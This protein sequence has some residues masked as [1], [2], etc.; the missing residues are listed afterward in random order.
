MDSSSSK[1]LEATQLGSLSLKNRVVLA[2]M[3]RAR[4][5]PD[6]IP[7]PIMAEYYAQRA[8]A[9]LVIT[10]ATTISPQGLGWVETPGIWTE[11][12]RDGW[13]P[14]VAAVQAQG[15]KIFLQLWHTGRAGHSSFL[16]GARPVSASAIAIEGEG[17]HGADG[18]KHPHETPR[19]LAT[20]ELPALVADYRQ[21][22][23]LAREAGFDGVEIHSANGY[24]LDQFLQSKTNQRSDSYGGSLENRYRLLGEVL[25]AVLAEWPAER[26]GVRLSPNGAFND[27]GS[28]DYREQFL[29]TA[30]QL[31]S[32]GLAYLHVMDGLAFGFHELGEPMTLAE[33]REPFHGPL[34]GNCGYD[35]AAAEER[36][37]SGHADLIAFGRPY[38]SNP[39]L[40]ERFAKGWPLSKEGD[41]STWYSPT[42]AQG[43]TDYPTAQVAG[44]KDF[45]G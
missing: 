33:F 35:Q 8:N 34:I 39:D 23:R 24:L 30:Q 31:N 43:Y 37:Q 6:R 3:T 27:M 22:A 21:A 29:Y 40:V 15:A 17:V 28:P 18:Q 5:G 10:E 26:I 13:K 1:L 9:G 2:P 42:G 14:V 20:E 44:E 19:P 32:H 11:A 12:M 36:L 16:G 41:M 7:Q 25:T 38:I 45:P 4:S